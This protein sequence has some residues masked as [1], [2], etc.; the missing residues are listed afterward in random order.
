MGG[1]KLFFSKFEDRSESVKLY[2]M[3]KSY[4][5]LAEGF[6]DIEAIAVVDVLRR[7]GVDVET[8]AIG[9]DREVR[10]A[11]GVTVIADR[12]LESVERDGVEC[13]IF[14]GGMP[15]AQ[16][17]ADCQP[18][19]EYMQRQYEEGCRIAAICAAPALVVGRLEP[20][21]E[22]RLTCYPGF[23][24]YLPENFQCS[25]E[26]VVVDGKVITGKGPGFAVQFGLTVLAH[27]RSEETAR[28]VAAGMLIA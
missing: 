13:L 15:G 1:K 27:L 5:F 14:P 28:E 10:S 6:E 16:N 3:K 21:R 22:L 18:L 11:H 26:G 8:V 23:E 24:K 19:R 7:G 9:K 2:H 4:L 25:G 12:T 17:L 20:G